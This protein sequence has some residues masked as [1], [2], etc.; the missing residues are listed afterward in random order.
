MSIERLSAE[1]ALML[2]PDAVWPQDI[3]ALIFLDGGPLYDEEGRFRVDTVC[4]AIAGR[5][6]L[7]P[8]FRQLLHIPP[9]DLGG[10]LWID[11]PAFDLANHVTVSQLPAPADERQLL[12]AVEAARSQRLDRSRPLWEMRFF[13]GMADGRVALF[14]RMHHAMADG[15]AGVA[16]MAAFL[17][18]DLE[19]SAGE[20]EPWFPEAMPT[21]AQLRD[22]VRRRVRERR[23]RALS[24]LAHPIKSIRPAAGALPAV[25][26]LLAQRPLA[27]TSLDRRVGPTRTFGLIR[28]RLDVVKNVAH[29]HGATV[30]DVLLAAVAGGIRNLLHSRGGPAPGELRAYV[31]ISLHRR[32][33]GE[34]RGNLISQMVVT[35]PLGET[36]P[37]SM[38]RQI[39]R[40]TARSKAKSHP[41][42][43]WMP[44]SGI[45]GRV[46]LKLVGRQRVNVTTADLPGPPVPMYFAG[47]RVLEVFPLTQLIGNV[48]IG[49]A[50]VSYAGQFN[51]MVVAD[52]DAYPDIDV[53][54]KSSAA[55]LDALAATAGMTTPRVGESPRR[56]AAAAAGG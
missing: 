18:A 37:A 26:E 31:P 2:W 30:N 11:A 13:T 28:S 33:G 34:A 22:D 48:S 50:A 16:T 49:V 21:E 8:R 51:L 44:H 12:L 36:D 55:Q 20:P 15:M 17:N 56:V 45:A 40:E 19:A 54:I 29:T 6:H 7:V 9:A 41:S 52:G 43:G 46:F 24:S 53:F 38:L 23:R 39:S 3:G 25:A 35:L 47:T 14:W 32:E 4:R 42:L 27:A 1:D 5:L 10:P